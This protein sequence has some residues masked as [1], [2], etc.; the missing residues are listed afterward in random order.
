MIKINLTINSSNV[1]RASYYIYVIIPLVFI[2]LLHYLFIIR[3]SHES[4]YLIRTTNVSDVTPNL[5]CDISYDDFRCASVPTKDCL[6]NIQLKSARILPL[7][8]FVLEI[9]FIREFFSLNGS[10]YKSYFVY[11]L[12]FFTAFGFVSILFIV[13]E[14]SCYYDDMAVVLWP[15]GTVLSFTIFVAVIDYHHGSF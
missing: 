10:C 4:V 9:C 1:Q 11:F 14:K 12:W 13:F 5:Y 15:V 7:V 8:I 3:D 2:Q 6:S